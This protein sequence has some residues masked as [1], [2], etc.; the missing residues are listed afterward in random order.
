MLYDDLYTLGN[1]RFVQLNKPSDLPFRT[2]S[3]HF[4]I[5]FNFLVYLIE[6]LVGGVILQYIEDKALLNSLLHRIH[7]ER[8]TLS[9]GIDRAEKL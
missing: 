2:C 7:M 5:F 4:W 8:F 9:V 1:I 6:G 3:L